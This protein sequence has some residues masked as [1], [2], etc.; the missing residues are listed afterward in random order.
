[1]SAPFGSR[2]LGSL[3]ELDLQKPRID[4]QRLDGILIHG[5]RLSL[6]LFSSG[7]WPIPAE[8]SGEIAVA[9]APFLSSGSR[10]GRRRERK[11]SWPFPNPSDSS[12]QRKR[13]TAQ[14]RPMRRRC[15]AA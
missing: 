6:A 9:L 3:M 14:D 4:R 11:E 8:R 1:M 2:M 10:P 7:R 15:S 5:I 13:P 12:A